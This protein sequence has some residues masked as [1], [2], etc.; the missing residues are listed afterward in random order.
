MRRTNKVGVM[1]KLPELAQGS[2]DQLLSVRAKS[3]GRAGDQGLTLARTTFSAS[4]SRISI[5]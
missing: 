3:L 2:L 5:D 4:L 1:L